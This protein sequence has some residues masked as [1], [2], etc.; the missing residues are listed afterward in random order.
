MW[1]EIF[2]LRITRFKACRF[3]LSSVYLRKIIAI[4]LLFIFL[5]NIM[6]YYA[7]FEIM[8]RQVRLEMKEKMASSAKIV[9]ILEI[10]DE[11][12]PGQFHW[13]HKE[14]FIYQGKMYDLIKKEKLP[15]STLYFCIHDH[16]EEKLLAGFQKNLDPN[17]RFLLSMLSQIIQD[18]VPPDQYHYTPQLTAGRIDFP[19]PIISFPLPCLT[20]FSPPPEISC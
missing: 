9:T 7:V 8:R 4:V 12:S 13:V 1:R 2:L 16:A 15:N 11:I 6:G 17:N 14:E 3:I 18:A 10:P 20:P 5:F 19:Q